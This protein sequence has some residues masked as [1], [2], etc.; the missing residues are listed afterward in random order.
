MSKQSLATLDDMIEATRQ[1]ATAKV[2]DEIAARAVAIAHER[3]TTKHSLELA[4]VIKD[5]VEA[6]ENITDFETD[7]PADLGS[8]FDAIDKLEAFHKVT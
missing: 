2:F 1:L 4:Q 6:K 5:V 3:V 8:L 7:Q